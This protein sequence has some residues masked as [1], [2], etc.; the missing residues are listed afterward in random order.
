MLLLLL[1]CKRSPAHLVG[2]DIFHGM[3]LTMMA[4]FFHSR[5]R[6]ADLHLLGLLLIGSVP[7]AIVGARVTT[8]IESIWF[9]RVLLILT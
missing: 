6:S 2:T 1:W 9:R 3:I 5:I 4:A 8:F 7:G